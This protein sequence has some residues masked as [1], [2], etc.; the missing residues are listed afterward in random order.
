MRYIY[1]VVYKRVQWRILIFYLFEAVD[2][3]G[4]YANAAS[5]LH[6][7]PSEVSKKN[8]QDEPVGEKS[9]NDF[10]RLGEA[11][12]IVRLSLTKNHHVP[13]PRLRARAPA[14]HLNWVRTIYLYSSKP[15]AG[16][17]YRLP[18]RSTAKTRVRPA[19]ITA[20]HLIFYV[21]G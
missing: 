14:I 4:F 1:C 19:D 20:R 7:I 6:H 11:R 13:T 9:S 16:T 15:Q 21:K 12:E 5:A 8:K 18:S 17:E 3:G 10:S 2:N